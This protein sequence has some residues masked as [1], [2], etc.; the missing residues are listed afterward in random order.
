MSWLTKL[1]PPKIKRE[2]GRSV[3]GQRCPKACG[4]SARPARRCS[5][6]P[7]SKTTS[8]SARSAATT[9]A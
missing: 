4:A 3:R 7:T 5:M 2:R 8:R 9:T 1:L 6:R